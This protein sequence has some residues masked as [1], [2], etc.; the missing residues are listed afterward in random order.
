MHSYQTTGVDSKIFVVIDCAG[1]RTG[2]TSS[3]VSTYTTDSTCDTTSVFTGECIWV[4]CET[5]YEDP[6]AELLEDFLRAVPDKRFVNSI[7]KQKYRMNPQQISRDV[8]I[9][10]YRAPQI[11]RCLRPRSALPSGSS[12]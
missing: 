8:K 3:S 9:R 6:L 5:V 1:T 10:N 7:D 4:E 11:D 12:Q 2:Y